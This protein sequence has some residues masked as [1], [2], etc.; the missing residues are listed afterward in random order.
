MDS[1][2]V[3]IF[4]LGKD[5]INWSI[6]KDREATTFLLRENGFIITGNI[7]KA[8]HI[9]CIWYDLLFGFRYRWLCYFKNIF[10]KKLIAVITNDITFTPE[11]LNF[12]K[13]FVDICIVPSE[14]IFKFLKERKIKAYKIPFFIEPKL[15]KPLSLSKQK[16]CEK[17]RIDYMS[18]KDKIIIGSFQRDSLGKNLLSPKWQKNPNLLIEILEKLPKEKYLLL[19][20]GPRRHYIIQKCE[21][22]NIPYLFYGDKTAIVSKKDDI[23]IN[24]LDLTTIN[25]LYNLADVYIITSKSEGGP[26]QVIESSLTKTLIFSTKVGLA[27]DI[28]HPYLLFEENEIQSLVEK[29]KKFFEHPEQFNKYIKYNFQKAREEMDLGILKEK[30]KRVILENQV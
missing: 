10:S 6:D 12:L 27:P 30:Y 29:I 5:K 9:F 11:K 18:I 3:K 22:K 17:L 19:L 21:E 25:Y 24:N 13:K 7:F 14:K 2:K 28:L 20:A 16:I 23:F 26:K 15:F 4:V 8:T 1:G